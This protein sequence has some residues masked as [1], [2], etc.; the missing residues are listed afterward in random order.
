MKINT[1][2]CLSVPSLPTGKEKERDGA[3]SP[4]GRGERQVWGAAGDAQQAGR[5]TRNGNEQAVR[6]SL[7][8]SVPT[9][10]VSL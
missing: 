10:L 9:M 8:M 6:G 4:V 7:L 3:C 2:L 1:D 5:V